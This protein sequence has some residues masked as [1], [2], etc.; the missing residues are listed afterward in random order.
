[1]SANKRWSRSE[2]ID[3]LGQPVEE[4]INAS[5]SE[6]SPEGHHVVTV[7]RLDNP[8]EGAFRIL[9]W[10]CTPPPPDAIELAAEC[11]SLRAK[12]DVESKQIEALVSRVRDAFDVIADNCTAAARVQNGEADVWVT[13]RVCSRHAKAGL[14]EDHTWGMF[15]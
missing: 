2:L 4:Y 14:I 8:V 1:M 3:I 10:Q 9:R 6:I 7:L 5:R 11:E 13:I 12:P 15:D